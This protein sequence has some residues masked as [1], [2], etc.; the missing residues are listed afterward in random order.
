MEVDEE[1]AIPDNSND[2]PSS[3]SAGIEDATTHGDDLQQHKQTS[4]DLVEFSDD[5]SQRAAALQSWIVSLLQKIEQSQCN[6]NGEEA[7]TPLPTYA[8]L[9]EEV[10]T[11]QAR[12]ACLQEHLEELARTRDEMVESDRRVRR[13]LYRLAAG[14]V[15]LKEVLKAIATADED[16]E[17]EAAWMEMTTHS[18]S[19]SLTATKLVAEKI[20]AEIDSQTDKL[21]TAINE[22]V[23]L[24]KKQVADL[25]EVALSRD[26]QIKKVSWICTVLLLLCLE[27]SETTRPLFL[28]FCS[29]FVLSISLF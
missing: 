23:S 27:C 20:K 28:I 7:Y 4:S 10:T 21:P 15:Q 18:A 6:S 3:G 14:R 26:E 9:Q 11:L 12:N 16:K 22:E 13:G 25:N 17:A 5:I 1:M 24:L 2:G 29:A 8:E 19:S